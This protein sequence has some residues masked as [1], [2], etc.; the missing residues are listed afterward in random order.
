MHT[1]CDP[2]CVKFKDRPEV[3]PGLMGGAGRSEA[4]EALHLHLGS[5]YEALDA[6]M[7]YAN[8]I[9]VLAHV[10]FKSQLRERDLRHIS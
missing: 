3:P 7:T 4:G 10:Y 1:L 9:N 8:K 5:G 6:H 2:V